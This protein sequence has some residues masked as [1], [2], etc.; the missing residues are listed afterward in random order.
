M[1]KKKNKIPIFIPRIDIKNSNLV[2]GV[3]LEGFR[4]LSKPEEFSSLYYEKG[5]EL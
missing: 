2:K 5:A 1:Y 4:V 3:N